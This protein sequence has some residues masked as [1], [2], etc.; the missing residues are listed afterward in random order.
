MIF[1]II[2]GGF[3]LFKKVTLLF[4]E[5]MDKKQLIHIR[6]DPS[7]R[8][9]MF[10]IHSIYQEQVIEEFIVEKDTIILK[11]IKTKS[12]GVME[13]YGFED[14]KECH[15][16]NKRLGRVFIVRRGMGEWQGIIIKGEKIYFS[17]IGDKGDRIRIRVTTV[18]LGK[19]FFL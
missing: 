7:N 19:A 6:I 9:S 16:I 11:G 1:L 2:G 5:N 3:F 10:Y 15:E 12:P 17:E 14:T 13:Y 18:S 8:F 4:I